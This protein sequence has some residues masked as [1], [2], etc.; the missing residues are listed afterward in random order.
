M[1]SAISSRRI[2][3]SAGRV[4]TG[5]SDRPRRPRPGPIAQAFASPP[6]I[7]AR[8]ATLRGAAL[9]NRKT[10]RRSVAASL[11]VLCC[12][13]PERRR[14][15][16]RS[17]RRPARSGSAR[18]RVRRPIAGIGLHPDPHLACGAT[19]TCPGGGLV[20]GSS[21]CLR[22]TG[23]GSRS[24]GTVRILRYSRPNW[25]GSA[26]YTKRRA[27]RD[28]VLEAALFVGVS[29]LAGRAGARVGRAVAE[30]RLADHRLAG[31]GDD[32]RA[33]QPASLDHPQVGAGLSP[34]RTRTPS[35]A[36]A[37]NRRPFGDDP[38]KR[39]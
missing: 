9:F 4:L 37:V 20:F 15:A 22:T 2:G 31:P 25:P 3:P 30:D 17:C 27:R 29:P 10:P 6:F 12:G 21:P 38:N 32:G 36:R 13:R 28:E 5:R 1:S 18:L 19:E 35:T 14:A 16:S 8:A 23:S 39:L 26:I 7:A 33:V 24:A 11:S 34:A